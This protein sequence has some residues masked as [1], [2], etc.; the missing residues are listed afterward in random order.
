M[1]VPANEVGS[2]PHPNAIP[3]AGSA[4]YNGHY[5][6]GSVYTGPSTTAS[7]L[8]V[9]VRVPDDYPEGNLTPE[10]NNFYYV[11]LSAWD[12]A[13]S[14]D[15]IGFTN[16]ESVWGLSYSWTSQCAGTY[17]YSPDV[18][19]LQRGQSY[20]FNMSFSAGS[21][22]YAVSYASNGTLVWSYFADTGGSTFEVSQYD[23]CEGT[24]YYDYT[25]Y[26]EVYNT[27]GPVVPYDLFF[28]HN[29]ADSSPVT[30]WSVWLS[31]GVPSGVDALLS[32]ANVT[33]ENEPYYL[34]FT[35]SLDSTVVEPTAPPRTFYWNV[36]VT[37]LSPDSPIY[38]AGYHV[39]N[40]WTLTIPT[41]TGSPPFTSEFSFSFPST[42]SAGHYYIGLNASDGSGSYNRVALD[43]NVLPMLSASPSGSPGSGGIDVGQSV[44]L[45]A[46]A[47]GGSG[48][49]NYDW[50]S[51]PTGCTATSTASVPCTPS[52]SGSF[53]ITVTVTDSLH[54]AVVGALTYT[55]DTD[56]TVTVPTATPGSVDLGQRVT[57]AVSATG[58][59]GA[60]SYVWKGLP[61]GCANSGAS[62]DS[63]VPTAAGTFSPNVTVTDSNG[64][65]V[66]SAALSFKVW[67][68]LIATLRGSVGSADV[69][70]TV[71]FDA[72]ATGG[73]GGYSYAWSGLPTGC[74]S[75]D[76]AELACLSTGAGT[77]SVNVTVVDSNGAAWNGTLAFVVYPDPSV[78]APSASTAP[79][80]VDLG[81]TVTFSV[82]ATG[83]SGGYTYA[84]SGLPTGCVS[85]ATPSISCT[86]TEAGDFSVA[87]NVTDSNGFIVTSRTLSYVVYTDPTVSSFGA[88]PGTVVQGSSTTFSTEAT[89]GKTPFTYS[90]L[91]L[92][93]GCSSENLSTFTCTPSATGTFTVE[94]VV[95]D[96]NGFK[97]TGNATLTVNAELLGLP[98]SEGYVYIGAVVALAAVTVA[99]VVLLVSRY[100]KRRGPTDTVPPPET[101]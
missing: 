69:G 56:P 26:E 33:V 65:T 58:G 53:S 97:V 36:T 80:G 51:L 2:P 81:E 25:D 73:S 91:G 86:P 1:S 3:V 20:D 60:Y 30:S 40:G 82:T 14:Y 4:S 52:S 88:S 44:T 48:G 84:W 27:T 18:L 9:T 92:P 21:V 13:G 67:S 50:T 39:P 34:T 24:L 19:T 100:R 93:G 28:T 49:Y 66:T 99:A 23:L 85:V 31:S 37:D 41:A 79:G 32:G 71:L 15:Q 8:Q 101:S 10:S 64:W 94:V 76:S 87:V 75:A 90:Y 38:L 6:A 42:T 83:G 57:L 12:N 17:Y 62:S 63:C 16:N 43:V 96:A 59:S 78:S 46:D 5:Y 70:Q 98:L 55:V 77:F 74:H 47:S 7:S 95:L 68:A 54:Y 72:N 29:V 22:L 11:A 45:S 89:G 61:T 35:N